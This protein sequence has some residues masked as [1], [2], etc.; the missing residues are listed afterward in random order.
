[1][2]IRGAEC[3]RCRD[4]GS[5]DRQGVRDAPARSPALADKRD[6]QLIEEL[7]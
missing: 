4:T 7:V 6:A 3:D 5:E 2:T 1:V